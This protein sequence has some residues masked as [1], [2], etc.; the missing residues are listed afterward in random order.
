MGEFEVLAIR[1]TGDRRLRELV[2]PSAAVWRIGER[3]DAHG[4]FKY[5]NSLVL[6]N[7]EVYVS[8]TGNRRVEVFDAATGDWVRGWPVVEAGASLYPFYLVV[9]SGVVVVCGVRE[10]GQIAPRSKTIRFRPLSLNVVNGYARW[11]QELRTRFVTYSTNGDWLGSSDEYNMGGVLNVREYD[12]TIYAW[13]RT[14][15]SLSMGANLVSAQGSESLWE[16]NLEENVAV[17][18]LT[19]NVWET[20]RDGSGFTTWVWHPLDTTDFVVGEYQGQR[21]MIAQH[22]NG[23]LHQCNS[24]NGG[25]YSKTYL[26]PFVDHPALGYDDGRVWFAGN[27]ISFAWAPGGPGNPVQGLPVGALWANPDRNLYDPGYNI[28][29]TLG[30]AVDGDLVYLLVWR[31]TDGGWFEPSTWGNT[32]STCVDAQNTHHCAFE[33]G[34]VLYHVAKALDAEV[35]GD[36]VEIV[37]NA[38]NP[39]LV[40]LTS[41]GLKVFYE[42]VYDNAVGVSLSDD[43]GETWRT[44]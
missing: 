38:M 36:P 16:F 34:S 9:C 15:S 41:G 10:V 22:G 32:V 42:S 26:G 35:W 2:D 27:W 13:A 21:I 17:H 31:T 8:D 25:V 12:G 11:G 7:G 28:A 4:Q 19:R 39:R 40:P 23:F 14:I 30:L 18:T 20:E 1:K 3:G 29:S 43:D 6:H 44:P 33:V 5:P 37:M 24:R